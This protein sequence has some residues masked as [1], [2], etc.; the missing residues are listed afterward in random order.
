MRR[1][2][3]DAMAEWP[4]E[5]EPGEMVA[6]EIRAR[7]GRIVIQ[8]RVELGLH[9][10]EIDGRPDGVRPHGFTTFLD[11]LRHRAAGRGLAPEGNSP[12]WSMNERQC[13]EADREFVQFH[14]RRAAWLTL[15]RYEKALADADHTLALMDFVC[16]HAESAD[17]IASHERLRDLV[18]FQRTRAAVALALKKD[19]PEEAIDLVRDGAEALS[20]TISKG[21]L[22]QEEDDEPDDTP[23]A[24]LVEQLKY[25]ENEIRKNYAVAPTLRE[26]L[27]EAIT[28]ENYER[29]ALI[30]DQIAARKSR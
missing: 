5:P 1:D 25:L 3:D 8:V 4:Y 9:Q 30:R 18:L 20:A 13:V 29:A 12:P 22:D 16:R 26:Q 7:D 21:A 10:M 14:H 28:R 24:A 15:E 2:I 23:N 17:Y 27:V 11:Y 6:R 19:R